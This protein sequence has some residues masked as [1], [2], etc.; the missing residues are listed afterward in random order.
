L[1]LRVTRFPNPIPRPAPG[2]GG[3]WRATRQ[4]TTTPCWA[5]SPRNSGTPIRR[6]FRRVRRPRGWIEDKLNRV[7]QITSH[8]DR[9]RRPSAAREALGFGPL[10]QARWTDASS[11]ECVPLI[12]ACA[13]QFVFLAG[14]PAAQ[15]A[16]DARLGR[17]LALFVKFSIQNNCRLRGAA[18]ET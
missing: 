4:R 1:S 11:V 7:G 13:E 6:A 9:M 10:V 15:R 5:K 14:R 8:T 12:P 17:A 16:S 18:H 3:C 2:I